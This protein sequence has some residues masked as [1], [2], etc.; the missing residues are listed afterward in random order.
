MP[1][2]L[3]NIVSDTVN[4]TTSLPGWYD[5]AQQNLTNSAVTAAGQVPGINDTA[6]GGFADKLSGDQNP[7]TQGQTTLNQIATGAANPWITDASGNV[8]PNT[9]TAMGGLFQ[10]QNQQLNQ[11]IPNV[12]S[13]ANAAGVASGQFGSLR[14]QTAVQKARGDALANLQAEQMKAALQNQ[15]TGA[16]AAA[17]LGTLGS[18]EG[19]TSIATGE[20]QQNSPLAGIT[21]LANILNSQKTGSTVSKSTQYSP[22]SQATGL[23]TA[24]GGTSGN[25]GILGQLFGATIKDPT[26]GRTISVPGILGKGGIS[27]VFSGLFNSNPNTAV[28]QATPGTY[29]LSDGGTY[30]VRADGSSYIT[31]R[32]GNMTNFDNSGQ[33]IDNRDVG[34]TSGSGAGGS[35]VLGGDT[36]GGDTTGGDTTGGDTTGVDTTGGDTIDTSS[37]LDYFNEP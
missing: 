17:G 3:N 5:T 37:G 9:N 34:D 33:V 18:Q 2:G 22:L 12:S 32:S 30:I 25:A 20:F 1:T 16:Q 28:E 11:L 7:F 36:T 31:D 23:I 13:G 8:T 14:G 35:E 19:Q 15:S 26:T 29:P 27:N 6:V 4:Q 24:L 21:D 10:A